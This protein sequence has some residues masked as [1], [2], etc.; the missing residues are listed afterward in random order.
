MVDEC[1]CVAIL[2]WCF[3]VIGHN[4]LLCSYSLRNKLRS[5]SENKRHLFVWNQ[6]PEKLT[7]RE[8]TL[9][10]ST[11]RKTWNKGN[12][13]RNWYREQSHCHAIHIDLCSIKQILSGCCGIK[14]RGIKQQL[15][16]NIYADCSRHDC[17]HWNDVLIPF[18]AFD[19][20]DLLNL[21][22]LSFGWQRAWGFACFFLFLLFPLF[23]REMLFQRRQIQSQRVQVQR[24]C[25]FVLDLAICA[26]VIECV[27]AR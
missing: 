2:S 27:G 21:L 11:T 8:A 4:T 13:A 9:R 17:Q 25:R 24:V 15:F 10:Q 16:L 18:G 3:V 14:Q 22:L 19:N 7:R 23:H 26:F 12:M 20:C 1:K 5:L 6:R